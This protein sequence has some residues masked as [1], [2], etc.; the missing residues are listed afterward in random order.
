MHCPSSHGLAFANS[1]VSD[2]REGERQPY[3]T[4]DQMVLVC[5]LVD[6]MFDMLGFS[7][8][9]IVLLSMSI[10]NFY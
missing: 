3:A 9:T 8:S 5:R 10:I 4:E 1:A 2:V 6:L 7:A